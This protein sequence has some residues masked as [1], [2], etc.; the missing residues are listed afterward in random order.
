MFVVMN[1]KKWNSLPADVRKL[2]EEVSGQ[3]IDEHGKAWDQLDEE[4]RK[5]SLDLGNKIVSL[6]P[7]ENARWQKAAQ[8]IIEGYIKDVSGKGLPA[9]KAV[10]EVESLIKQYG[11]IYK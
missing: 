4:G 11:K 2:M 6:S 10:T 3:W 5:Y 8:P 9:Q 1:L 7:S